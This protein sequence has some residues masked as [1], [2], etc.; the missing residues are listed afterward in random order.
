MT[1]GKG[2][3]VVEGEHFGN[4]A[5]GATK[6]NGKLAVVHILNAETV[7]QVKQKVALNASVAQLFSAPL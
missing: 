6:G 3:T 4:T 7:R 5:V 1:G 2:L